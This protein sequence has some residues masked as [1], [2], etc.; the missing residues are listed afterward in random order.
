MLT[1][2]KKISRKIKEAVL[3]IELETRYSKDEIL[4]F[5]LNEIPYGSNAYGIEAAAQTFF[6]KQAKD[7]NLAESA[8]LAAVIKA[9]SYYS[10]Y[11][12]HPEELKNRQNLV[13]NRMAELN[14]ISQE[15]AAAAKKEEPKFSPQAHGLKAPHFVMYVKEYLEEKYGQDYVEK[16]GLKVYTTLDWDL[17]SIAEEIISEGAK[18]NWTKYKAYNAA[19]AAVDPKTGQILA[20]VGSRDYFDL[21]HDGNVNVTLRDRQPG[22]SFK[23]FAYAE[24]FKKGYTAETILF[25]L[26]TE[27][28]PNC[29]ADGTGEKD[30]YGLDC[31]NP[32]DYDDKFRGPVTIR[33]ALAQSL[34]LPSVQV[35]Y[36]AGVPG[37][38][39]LAKEMGISTLN[40]P[41]RYGL[42]LVLGGGEV[43][44]LDEVAAYSVFANDGIKNEK[45]PILK[46]EDAKG[47]VIE[48]FK[49]RPKKVLEPQISRLVSDI[50][51]DNAAR[52][53]IF[54]ENSALYFSDRPVAAKTG[55]TE[56]YR[57]AWTL[58]YTPSLS[59][60]LWVG[61]NDN[62]S[63]A[64]SGAGIAAAGPLWH[65]F[66]KKAYENKIKNCQGQEEQPENLFCLPKEPE[67]FQ[68]PETK[69][70]SKS[71]LNGS[72]FTERSY[73]VNKIS[74]EP[75]NSETPAELLEERRSKEVHNILYYVKKGDPQGEIPQEP[76]N[77]PQY[78]NWEAPVQNWAGQQGFNNGPVSQNDQNSGQLKITILKPQ[79][80]E[81]LVQNFIFTVSFSAPL[82]L[83][84]IDFFANDNFLGSISG[85][86]YE[87]NVDLKSISAGLNILKAK[88]YDRA[89][90]RQED[91]IAVF[92][93]K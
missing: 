42:S 81:V 62:S 19:L 80:N 12:S 45:T 47:K 24:A 16:A 13:L 14:F 87:I 53:P 83:S 25:D 32:G 23:P 7:L 52:S 31:Y 57:D 75:A 71:I 17:Q 26:K 15:E 70:T 21:E 2:E 6:N 37:T 40:D 90:N 18:N 76:A 9:P 68:K 44:L 27:F 91:Q 49:S 74:G 30:E 58:G 66:I 20:M 67:A 79:G 69:S 38:I 61:N 43:K 59:V 36:L 65:S 39:K 10:P 63:M 11:G 5:Y 1:S 22:S 4:N 29:P 48:E 46:I 56:K 54:G 77:D 33:E 84:Q 88:I 72:Y 35:L 8:L 34:N 78:K 51:S 92:V 89:L 28:N 60:G 64:K 3:A 55:T 73:W 86:P 50:L 82:G 41:D 93:N 85:P